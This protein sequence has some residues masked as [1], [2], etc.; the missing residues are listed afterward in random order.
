MVDG[1]SSGTPKLHQSKCGVR[2][3]NTHS[4]KHLFLLRAPEV[5]CDLTHVLPHSIGRLSI[6]PGARAREGCRGFPS[7]PAPLGPAP[8]LAQQVS[9][10]AGGSSLAEPFQCS[11]LKL[12]DPSLVLYSRAVLLSVWH[13]G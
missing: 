13:R 3:V 10:S 9:G 11:R 4:N 2:R 1:A 7:L 5:S 6:T 8:S 12:G